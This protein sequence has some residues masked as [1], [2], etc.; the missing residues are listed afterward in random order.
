MSKELNDKLV[1]LA[2]ETLQ[3]KVAKLEK[4]LYEVKSSRDYWEHIAMGK[5]I[6]FEKRNNDE[7]HP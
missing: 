5:L 4:E 1:A 2:I 6:D 3:D 7:R